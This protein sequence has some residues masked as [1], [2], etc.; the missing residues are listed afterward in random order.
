MYLFYKIICLGLILFFGIAIMP[1]Q[2]LPAGW[3]SEDI[4]DANADEGRAVFDQGEFYVTGGGTDIWGSSDEFHFVY[5]TFEG[6]GYI[7]AKIWALEDAPNGWAKAGIMM[8]EDLSDG[9]PFVNVINT[10]DFGVHMHRR[11]TYDE[12]IGS[13][14]DSY[15]EPDEQLRYANSGTRYDVWAKLERV[16]QDITGSYSLDGVEWNEIVTRTMEEMTSD[17]FFIGLCVTSHTATVTYEGV[18]SDVDYTGQSTGI[19]EKLSDTIVQDFVLHENYPNPFNPS[20]KIPFE[21]NKPGAIKITIYDLLGR[22]VT[23]LVNKFHSPGSYAVNWSVP[24]TVSS[25]IYYY[26]LE[27]G[28]YQSPMKKMVMIK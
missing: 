1:A 5:R 8:R 20:T 19:K 7:M 6:D 21:V 23:Q 17:T 25:G 14:P 11:Y 16:E 27:S 3:F 18:F 22:E 28:N 12:D 13:N 2:E 26:I 10:A 4:G 9:S 15:T 24:S